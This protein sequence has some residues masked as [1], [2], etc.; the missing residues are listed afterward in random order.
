MLGRRHSVSGFWTPRAAGSDTPVAAMDQTRASAP[1]PDL[2]DLVD[3]LTRETEVER[4]LRLQPA[5]VV[6]MPR[7]L[8]LTRLLV[9]L[10]VL[11]L[12]GMAWLMARLD[13]QV[14]ALVVEVREHQRTS[15]VVRQPPLPAP[16]VLIADDSFAAA[17]ARAPDQAPRL[18]V[19]RGHLLLAD[20]RAAAAVEAFAAAARSSELP[21]SSFDRLGWAAAQLE[22]GAPQ[23]ARATVLVLD[24]AA[25]TP[26]ERGLAAEL[27]TRCVHAAP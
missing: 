24:H 17:L 6:A 21:L 27:L 3:A 2:D 15:E 8:P 20:H 1:Q 10:V 16:A 7:P 19:A 23:A 12:G 18:L 4:V 9:V 5:R 13:G 25:L 22:A 11:L 14:R 26:A